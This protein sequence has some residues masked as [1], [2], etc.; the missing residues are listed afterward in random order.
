MLLATAYATV[1]I[2]I[3]TPDD[4]YSLAPPNVIE[5]CTRLSPRLERLLSDFR[6]ETLIYTPTPIGPHWLASTRKRIRTSIMPNYQAGANDGRWL[7]QE[8]ADAADAFFRETADLLPGEPFI[9]SSRLGD[10]VAEFKAEH[11]TMTS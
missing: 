10:L 6:P 3:R 7:S 11:G 2:R 9:Y 1:S 4:V 5:E 8:V